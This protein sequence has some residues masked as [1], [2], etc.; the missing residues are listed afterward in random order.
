MLSR[1]E[2]TRLS[3]KSFF[4]VFLDFSVQIRAVIKFR[5]RKNIPYTI[6]CHILSINYNKTHKSRLKCEIKDDMYKNFTKK[7]KNLTF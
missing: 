6:L 2:K 3:G 7:T 4:V 5:P 1:L